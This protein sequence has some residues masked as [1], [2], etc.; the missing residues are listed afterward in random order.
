[1]NVRFRRFSAHKAPSSS[2][3]IAVEPVAV[4][5]VAWRV[6]PADAEFESMFRVSFPTG[7]AA[8]VGVLGLASMLAGAPAAVA[9]D[10]DYYDPPPVT[11]RYDPPPYRGP[12]YDAPPVIHRHIER[13]GPCRIVLRRAVD[14]YGREIVRRIREC[15]EGVVAPGPRWAGRNPYDGG[16]RFYDPAPRPPR[17]VGPEYRAPDYRAPDYRGDYRGPADGPYDDED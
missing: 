13:D 9:A 17:S 1:M 11:H 16:P 8:G 7:K 6:E 5:E 10:I 3:S 14:P 12:V 15:D 2:V 4:R